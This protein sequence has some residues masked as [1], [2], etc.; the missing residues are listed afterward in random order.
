MGNDGTDSITTFIANWREWNCQRV[1]L[2]NTTS[3]M[4]RILTT[5]FIG[6]WSSG[7]CIRTELTWKA[8]PSIPAAWWTSETPMALSWPDPNIIFMGTLL[9]HCTSFQLS[10]LNGRKG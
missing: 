7:V 4:H 5:A 1:V 8:R 10:I 3:T 2:S 6:V 9:A